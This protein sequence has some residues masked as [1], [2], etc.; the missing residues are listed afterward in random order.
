MTINLDYIHPRWLTMVPGSGECQICVNPEGNSRCYYLNIKYNGDDKF[1][2]LVCSKEEC[3][4]CIREYM[5]KLYSNIYNTKTWKRILNIY[6]NNLFISVER[7]NGTIEHDWVLDNYWDHDSNKNSLQTSFLYAILCNNKNY[8]NGQCSK[9]PNEIWEYI[10]NICLETYTENINLT[11]SCY[12][13][14]NIKTFI[15]AKKDN[16]YKKILIDS[17]L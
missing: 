2:Y 17:I 9:L 7:S 11:L 12:N 3:N 16:I 1:G 5:N 15:R 6:A 8:E 14:D 10:Y 4:L 13:K